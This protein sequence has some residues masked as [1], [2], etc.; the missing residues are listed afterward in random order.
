MNR[1][2][3]GLIGISV[4]AAFVVAATACSVETQAS[5]VICIPDQSNICTDCKKPDGDTQTYAGRH[6]C[7]HDGKSFGA[8]ESCAPQVEKS[9]FNELPPDPKGDDDDDGPPP[10][11]P[12]KDTIEAACAGKI[13]IIAGKDDEASPFTYSAVYEGTKFKPYSSS[14]TPMR[15]PAVAA[16][17]GASVLVVYR[18]KNNS[19]ISTTFAGGLWGAASSVAGASLD[20]APGLTAWDGKLKAVFREDDGY[21]HVATFLPSGGASGG[22]AWQDG[23]E[24]VGSSTITPPPGISDPSVV[25]T[26]AAGLTGAGVLV[27]YTDNAKG[28][29]RQEWKGT[30]WFTKGIKATSV[31]AGQ[32]RPTIVAMT[33]GNFDL[34][35]LYINAD[36]VLRVSTRTSKDNGTLWSVDTAT[37]E[38]AKPASIVSG[39]GLDNGRALVVYLDAEKKAQYLVFDPSKTPAWT[40]PAPLLEDNPVLTSAPQVTRDPCGAEAL[41]AL[42][43]DAGVAVVRF[44]ANAFKGPYLVDGIPGITYATAIAAP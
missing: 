14:G 39:V 12:A 8:C 33:S 38:A 5:N 40:D 25:S 37:S 22:G 15:S 28:L 19:L 26:G 23:I 27:G 41:I 32:Y 44:A 43:T 10:I 36:G 4:A 17:N 29:Y 1:L 20:G 13:A 2:G 31:Q 24:L 11:T 16:P 42:P 9:P 3:L 18:S 35:S 6:T 7:A 21:H 34:L 30:S